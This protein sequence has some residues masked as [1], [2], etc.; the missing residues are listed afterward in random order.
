MCSSP[1][2]ELQKIFIIMT[3]LN[4]KRGHL[5]ELIATLSFL[6][7]YLCGISAQALNYFFF[8][9]SLQQSSSNGA[10]D[11]QKVEGGCLSPEPA[12]EQRSTD[13]KRVSRDSDTRSVSLLEQK[14][15]VVSSSID[16]PH[17]R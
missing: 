14:R 11:G 5:K 10:P 13:G 8:F 7:T 6:P 15:K 4:K 12:D 2:T 3:L 16:V 1:V 17:A 9:A